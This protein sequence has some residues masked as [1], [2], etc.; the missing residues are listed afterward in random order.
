MKSMEEMLKAV[1][2]LEK[3]WLE[4]QALRIL[5]KQTP[6]TPLFRLQE[7]LQLHIG[8]PTTQDL[9]RR[10]FAPLRELVQQSPQAEKVLSSLL[11]VI[12]DIPLSAP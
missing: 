6:S 7:A 1:D 12:Q 2:H 9:A 4:N 11:P 8:D 5:L 3:L 10:R